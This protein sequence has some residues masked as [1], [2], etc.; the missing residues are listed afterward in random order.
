MSYML[1]YLH[2]GSYMFRQD[3]AYLREQLGSFLS[4]FNFSMIGG[5]SEYNRIMQLSMNKD[6]KNIK[7]I[8]N[9]NT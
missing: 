8:K 7:C 1:L 2:E 3:N 5:K 4:Y 6:N 9:L